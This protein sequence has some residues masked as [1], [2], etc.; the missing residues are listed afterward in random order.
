[1][2]DEEEYEKDIATGR[3]TELPL[4]HGVLLTLNY[5]PEFNNISLSVYT[6]NMPGFTIG[7]PTEDWPAVQAWVAS[8]N[9][10]GRAQ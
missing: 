5:F 3:R 4:S 10:R 6:K 9:W 7:L 8:F 2:T 1:M